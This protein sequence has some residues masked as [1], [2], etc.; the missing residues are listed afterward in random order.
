MFR[1]RATRLHRMLVPLVSGVILWSLI[2]TV[3]FAADKTFSASFG[4]N[5]QF[6][7]FDAGGSYGVGS[8]A[9]IPLVLK[10]QPTSQVQFG[11]ANLTPPPGVIVRSARIGTTVLDTSGGIIRARNLNLA[12]GAAVTVDVSAEV[13]CQSNPD[14]TPYNWSIQAKQ[15]NDFNG[16]GND[17]VQVGTLTNTITGTCSLEF[18]E[19]PASA[20]NAP[21]AITSKIYDDKIPPAKRVTVRVKAATGDETVTWWSGSISLGIGDNQSGGDPG[22]TGGAALVGSGHGVYEFAPKIS[23]TASGY[24]LIATAS[25]DNSASEGTSSGLESSNFN[26]V[27][28]ATICGE[29]TGC[30]VRTNG[31][32]TVAQVNADANGGVAGDVVILELSPVVPIAQRCGTYVPTSDLVVFNV[33]KGDG[34]TPSNRP[35]TATLTIAAQFVTQSASKYQ[36]CYQGATGAAQFLSACA[37]KNPILPCILSKTIDK[38]GNLVVVVGAPGG[39]PKIYA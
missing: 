4:L 5:N 9:A 14:L 29:T 19:Q 11:S 24:S 39:D 10:N 33:T 8:R 3:A 21:V 23:V 27:D 32:K 16:T 12:A 30:F 18:S 34:T 2:T 1:A 28:E 17:L 25:P 26:I 15:A 13:E 22:F 35:K 37:N 36:V 38:S 6:A 7:T 31:P 20:A